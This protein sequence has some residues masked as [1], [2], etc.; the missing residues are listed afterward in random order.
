[1]KEDLL[2]DRSI[3]DLTSRKNHTIERRHAKKGA[4]RE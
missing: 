3:A 2:N 1:M 4:S